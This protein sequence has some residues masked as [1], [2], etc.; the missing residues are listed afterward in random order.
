MTQHDHIL[1]TNEPL[2]ARRF[3]LWVCAAPLALNA[4]APSSSDPAVEEGAVQGNQTALEDAEPVS[5]L[6]PE[7]ELPEAE[8]TPLTI[9][10]Y[11]ATI[12]FPDGGRTLDA[13]ALATLE[14]AL[15]SPALP[16]GLPITLRAH[17]DSQGGDQA[18]LNAS[19]KR[20]L[21]VAQWLIDNGVD[22]SRITVIAFGEQNPVAPNALP[23]GSPNKAGRAQNRRVEIEIAAPQ[24]PAEGGG[25]TSADTKEP[26]ANVDSV[27]AG[28]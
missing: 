8:P 27:K 25:T 21:A 13:D 17:S 4:C 14:A 9:A 1:I 7:I 19:E 26:G 2:W 5:I 23:D 22:A 20:G 15:A 28:D 11:R 16:L 6:R 24:T 18:N 12:G 10:T 3:G